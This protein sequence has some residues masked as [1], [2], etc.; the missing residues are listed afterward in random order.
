MKQI[1]SLLVLVVLLL[2]NSVHASA[3]ISQMEIM[4]LTATETLKRLQLSLIAKAKSIEES[5]KKKLGGVI[6][7]FGSLINSALPASSKQAD[8]QAD[9]DELA[10]YYQA[11]NY[12]DIMSLRFLKKHCIETGLIVPATDPILCSNYFPLLIKTIEGRIG[13]VTSHY[14]YS[15]NILKAPAEWPE[16]A[17]EILIL[18][19]DLSAEPGIVYSVE[20]TLI[21]AMKAKAEGKSDGVYTD[22]PAASPVTSMIISDFIP[23]NPATSPVQGQNPVMQQQAPMLQGQQT[24]MFQGQQSYQGQHAPIYQGQEPPVFSG[25]LAPMI[26]GQM[27]QQILMLQGQQAPPMVNGQVLQQFPMGQGQMTQ[28]PGQA[29]APIYQGP[30]GQGQYST[31]QAQMAQRQNMQLDQVAQQASVFQGQAPQLCP[32][33]QGQM[34]ANQGP[35]AQT[36]A[37]QQGQQG[38]QVQGQVMQNPVPLVQRQLMQQGHQQ[39]PTPQIISNSAPFVQ[40]QVIGI[41][42]PVQPSNQ[43]AS[44]YDKS[45]Q[46][47]PMFMVPASAIPCF[48]NNADENINNITKSS[49]RDTYSNHT[50]NNDSNIHY[51][52]SSIIH[53]HESNNTPNI[54]NDSN[55]TVN[56]YSNNTLQNDSSIIPTNENNNTQAL[57]GTLAPK[58]PSKSRLAWLFGSK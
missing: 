18:L 4:N 52:D 23:S 33:T 24:S 42:T 9:L 49:D 54:N 53:N 32:C 46:M 43:P 37:L 25:Q 48:K 29:Q 17:L 6:G 27:P 11:M 5:S 8:P 45:V 57:P 26:Q 41:Q 51:H 13:T 16:H 19:G 40:G 30:Q 28:Q 44:N 35:I 58:A 1:S 2:G 34:M 56:S 47:V 36:Q 20:K 3:Q 7:V 31:Q 50:P 39:V 38:L 55:Y 12:A 21:K 10:G 22:A 15:D 14:L